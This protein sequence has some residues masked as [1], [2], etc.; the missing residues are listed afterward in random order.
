MSVTAA[1]PENMR[2][3]AWVV[4]PAAAAILCALVLAVLW[5]YAPTFFRLN[6][7]VNILVQALEA[8]PK[9]RTSRSGCPGMRAKAR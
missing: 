3:L 9:P 5:L 2:S 8:V 1:Y 6:N 4:R 7:L